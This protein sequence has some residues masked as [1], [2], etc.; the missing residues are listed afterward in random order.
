MTTLIEKPTRPDDDDCCGGGCSPCVWDT[1]NQ[2][3]SLWLEQQGEKALVIA[4][5]TD[6]I[7][8]R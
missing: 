4:E 6:E 7:L 2:Q 3:L 5:A 8:Y 1:Y